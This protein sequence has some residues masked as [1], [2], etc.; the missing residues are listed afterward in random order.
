VPLS[1]VSLLVSVK[2][3]RELAGFLL[4]CADE[5][6]RR[7]RPYGSDTHFHLRDFLPDEVDADVIVVPVHETT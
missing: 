7:K 5:M 4:S 2:A 6:D 1:E 3:M